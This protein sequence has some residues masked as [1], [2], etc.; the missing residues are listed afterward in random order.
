MYSCS[1][2]F[3]FILYCCCCCCFCVFSTWKC[4][5]QRVQKTT[6]TNIIKR[7]LCLD[8]ATH[9][10]S[11]YSLPND[12]SKDTST[13]YFNCVVL[14][15]VYWIHNTV[16]YIISYLTYRCSCSC[17]CYCCY[18]CCFYKELC[19]VS[20]AV[21]FQISASFTLFNRYRRIYKQNVFYWENEF[22]GAV[23]SEKENFDII[24]CG[25]GS[26]HKNL[27]FIIHSFIS[28]YLMFFS[29]FHVCFPIHGY[30][31]VVLFRCWKTFS[32]SPMFFHST[33]DTL[34]SL[35]IS[36]NAS[37]F[38]LFVCYVECFEGKQY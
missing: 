34:L 13:K 2:T 23:R 8:I 22:E 4:W 33:L 6:R 37:F 10:L 18:C 35:S 17:Y 24:Q 32:P 1:K 16:L 19:G 14:L 5:I 7:T 3:F 30:L 29:F 20:I 9:I 38:M 15:F 12:T 26:A 31:M 11:C 36:R 25:R 27:G 21:Y 28:R